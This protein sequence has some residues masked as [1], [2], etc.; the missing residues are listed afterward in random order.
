MSDTQKPDLKAN[1]DLEAEA[2]RMGDY[3]LHPLV[4]RISQRFGLFN[5]VRNARNQ[6]QVDIEKAT[7]Q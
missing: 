3:P 6:N 7:N 2:K 1:K 4:S 5:M